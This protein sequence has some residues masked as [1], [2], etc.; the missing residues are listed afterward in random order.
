MA[1]SVPKL[2]RYSR[3][4]EIRIYASA[5]SSSYCFRGETSIYSRCVA[6][7]FLSVELYKET[8]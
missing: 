6:F 1:H 7:L 4:Y 5:S 8:R 2:F 3:S